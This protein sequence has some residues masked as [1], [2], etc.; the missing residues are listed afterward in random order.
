MRFCPL[1]S[2]AHSL[3]NKTLTKSLKGVFVSK[4]F[5]RVYC[6][7][8]QG[9]DAVEVQVEVNLGKGMPAFQIIG[10][11]ETT[12]REA[13]DR[14]KTAIINSGLPFPVA[15][16]TVNLSPAELP[17]Q[18]ARFDLAIALGILAAEGVFPIEKLDNLEFYGELALNGE[19]RPILGLLPSLIATQKRQRLALIAHD[20]QADAHILR[21]P[22]A[23]SARTLVEA[24][25]H[26][27]QS[28]P[29]PLIEPIP[30][31]YQPP[32]H[33]ELADVQGQILAKRALLIAAAGGHHVLFVGPPGTGKTM[34]AKRLLGILP[35][36]SEPDALEVAAIQSLSGEPL[37]LE[38]WRVRPF[39]SPHHSCSAAALVGGGSAPKPGE[40]TRAHKGVLFLDELTEMP[41]HILD[42]L[43]EP[44]ESGQVHIS[45]AKAHTVFPAEFQ[46]VCALNP[47]P[48][49]HFDGDL[50]SARATP[51]QI[52]N[53][54]ARISGP[55]LDRIDLQVEVPRQ[56][57]VLKQNKKSPPKETEK[58]ACVAK[59]VFQAQQIQL[60]R[61]GCLNKS[62]SINQLEAVCQLS[63][64]D[65]EF[66]HS[67]IEKLN[68]SH[69]AYHRTLRLARTIA[70][71][72]SSSQIQRTHIAEAM[73]YRALDTLLQSLKNL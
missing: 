25:R 65:F 72:E 3:Q 70:D 17:K 29:L 53:Y 12:I 68:L 39:Q 55:F 62:L 49:G 47:S 35:P 22:L 63:E 8:L 23:F 7:A 16:I 15:K 6:R 46:L 28:Q 30:L 56:P 1:A 57:E 48:C 71:L 45:R 59:Q 44:L 32:T 40:I 14:V 64:A 42:T 73:S 51:D 36:L 27:N 20:N 13:R 33:Y 50:T 10:M 69:R 37:A 19:I 11:P 67:A 60:N 24:V 43:R 9:V 41:R 54:L 2:A 21:A 66:I 31:N 58:S 52:L 61:Q 5:A 26:L 18:G 38:Q 34:L 4:G